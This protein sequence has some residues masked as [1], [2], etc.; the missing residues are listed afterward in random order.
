MPAICTPC[1][2]VLSDQARK[3]ITSMQARAALAGWELRR[4]PDGEFIACRWD[5][6][7]ELPNVAAVE[8]FLVRVGAPG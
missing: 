3:V 8:R 1:P 5:R 4:M 6:M 7:A 2:E